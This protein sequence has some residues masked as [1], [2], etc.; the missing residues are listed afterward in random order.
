M[1]EKSNL[2]AQEIWYEIEYCDND[3]WYSLSPSYY[4]LR[5]GVDAI[6]KRRANAQSAVLYRLIQKTISSVEVG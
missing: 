2:V 6:S 3:N 1:P 4:T 5:G